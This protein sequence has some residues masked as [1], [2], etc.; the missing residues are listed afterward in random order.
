MVIIVGMYSVWELERG[1]RFSNGFKVDET[2][3][4][5]SSQSFGNA[6]VRP[7]CKEASLVK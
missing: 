1:N 3:R 2:D 5:V 4:Q 6:S 7:S